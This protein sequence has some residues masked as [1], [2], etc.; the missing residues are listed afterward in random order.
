MIGVCS[1]ARGLAA[2][3]LLAAAAT[4][5]RVAAPA[6]A[7]TG[8]SGLSYIS[9]GTWTVDPANAR[10]HVALA[11]TATSHAVDTGGRRYY[12]SGLALT[13]PPSTAAFAATDLDGDSLPVTV[14]ATTASGVGVEV[15]FEQRLYSGQSVS[16]GFTFDLVDAGGSTDRDL[17]IGHDVVSFPVTAFGSPSTPG[18]SV[19]VVFP[20]GFT[21]TEQFGALTGA[22]DRSDQTV[23][24]SGIV[25]DA[26]AL[27][28]WFSAS[29]NVPDADFLTTGIALGPIPVT[30]RYW[31][32]D[33]AWASQVSGILSSGYPILR[34]LIGLGDPAIRSLTV[35]ET[36]TQ[37]IGGFSGEYDPASGTVKVS[38]FADPVVVLHEA[39]H[40]WFNANL[41]SD[42]WIEE[43]FASY[44]AEAAILKLGLPDHSPTLSAQL[45]GV[46]APLNEWTSSGLPNTATEA[47]F[48]G[49]SLQMARDVAAAAGMDGLR[50]AWTM[51]ASHQS[52][53]PG[54]EAQ[55]SGSAATG[56]TDWRR[57]LDYLE[58]A[59][60][61]TFTAI[62]RHWVV[63]PSQAAQ[64]DDRDVTR[65]QYKSM[66]VLVGW[67]LPPDIRQA[68]G[69]WISGRRGC[70]WARS[71]RSS[72]TGSRSR[73]PRL[74][75]TC[76][77]RG[78][79]G[80]PFRRRGRPRRLRR[81]RA[82][83]RP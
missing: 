27:D 65:A 70:F 54:T 44:Y 18:S 61:Q 49:A 77:L 63:S 9:T 59:T 64:L 2:A 39:A 79:S 56:P 81:R 30:L 37:G 68:M 74:S 38:Y 15:A 52:P 46:A 19:S 14:N 33:P 28:A 17:R 36:T 5:L 60:G 57:L 6:A 45:L 13:L 47:Y 29:R 3:L 75:R 11:V 76:H 43:G 58:L 62:W 7:D 83:C 26:T 78:R 35:E 24:S 42:R 8:Q 22:T 23:F 80:Q 20:A 66:Q 34:Q 67:D 51:A 69:A 71:P 53:Y 73:R 1:S 4:L 31:A 16:F 32:D 25:P 50:Q 10:V 72:T 21:A 41:T 55:G 12:F 48:Y 82:S 40:M